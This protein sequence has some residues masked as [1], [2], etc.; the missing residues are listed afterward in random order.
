MTTFKVWG[1]Q[2]VANSSL[3]YARMKASLKPMEV[4]ILIAGKDW[5]GILAVGDSLGSALQV[6]KKRLCTRSSLE[7]WAGQQ[8]KY[9]C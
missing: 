4:T 8:G 5:S 6:S 2:Q 7:K 9:T 3:V 1:Q